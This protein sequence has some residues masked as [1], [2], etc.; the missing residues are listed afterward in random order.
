MY[1]TEAMPLFKSSIKILDC[2]IQR[3]IGNI[4][5]AY[6]NDNIFIIRMCDLKHTGTIIQHPQLAL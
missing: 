6:D 4:F 1:A 2:C 3:A 5:S